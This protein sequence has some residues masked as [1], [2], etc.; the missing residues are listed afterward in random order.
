MRFYLYFSTNIDWNSKNI[1]KL[2]QT[3]ELDILKTDNECMNEYAY[4]Y[5]FIKL[6]SYK[7]PFDNILT[8]FSFLSR[9]TNLI[10]KLDKIYNHNFCYLKELN[11]YLIISNT[12]NIFL[13]DNRGI[14]IF[15]KIIEKEF[16]IL[17]IR[18]IKFFNLNELIE[19]NN[20][21]IINN[22][23]NIRKNNNNRKLFDNFIT[24]E[25]K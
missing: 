6:G 22:I 2:N 12:D 18:L 10:N 13:D 20:Y 11:N 21:F 7:L 5:E 19:I 17:G 25:I 1:I 16:P 4:I 23:N 24:K 9:N 14:D 3:D 15:E 8:I